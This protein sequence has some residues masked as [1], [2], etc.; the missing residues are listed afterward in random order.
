MRDGGRLEALGGYLLY[1]AGF[2]TYGN[3]IKSVF[4][5]EEMH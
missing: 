1:E 2:E 4:F 3:K 5:F